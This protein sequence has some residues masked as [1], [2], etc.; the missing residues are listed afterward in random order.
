MRSSR[1]PSL[2]HFLSSAVNIALRNL[3]RGTGYFPEKTLGFALFRPVLK[4][5][6]SARERAC[7]P[8]VVRAQAWFA[9][10]LTAKPFLQK[11]E[12]HAL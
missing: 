11:F 6:Y 10:Q 12:Q 8:T 5:D 7:Q 9:S 2:A 4:F 1:L 3:G